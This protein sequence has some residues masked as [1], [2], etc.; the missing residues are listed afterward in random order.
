MLF[1]SSVTAL[2]SLAQYFA[3]PPEYFFHREFARHTVERAIGFAVG[4]VVDDFA[5]GFVMSGALRHS[6]FTRYGPSYRIWRG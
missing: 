1:R 5:A 6:S 4:F 2:P 3:T